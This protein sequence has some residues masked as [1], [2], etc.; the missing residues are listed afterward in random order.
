MIEDRLK[1]CRACTCRQ[2]FFD[3]EPDPVWM[4]ACAQLIMGMPMRYETLICDMGTVLSGGQKQR[5]LLARA[6]YKRPKILF[7]DEATSHLDVARER[8][9]NEAIRQLKLTRVIIAHRPETIA[10]ADRI[11]DLGQENSVAMAA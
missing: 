10:A 4:L 7:L 8:R 11:V 1:P 3:P 2:T 5:V 9:V 6:L